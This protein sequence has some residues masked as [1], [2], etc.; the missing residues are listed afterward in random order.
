MQAYWILLSKAVQGVVAH[1]IKRK[2]SP[3]VLAESEP[4]WKL[5]SPYW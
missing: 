2:L 5:G 3:C 1:G 4:S